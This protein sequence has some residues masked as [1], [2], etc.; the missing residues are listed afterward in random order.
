VIEKILFGMPVKIQL[1]DVN[2]YK[3]LRC[4]IFVSETV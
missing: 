1:K 2:H 4:A 3:A